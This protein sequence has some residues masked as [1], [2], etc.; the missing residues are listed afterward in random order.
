MNIEN[1]YIKTFVFII[2]LTLF[3][4]LSIVTVFLLQDIQVRPKEDPVSP[5]FSSCIDGFDVRNTDISD[6]KSF[7]Q[8][9]SG[10]FGPGNDVEVELEAKVPNQELEK[11]DIEFNKTD[12]KG[13]SFLYYSKEEDNFYLNS[14]YFGNIKRTSLMVEPLTKFEVGEYKQTNFEE[15]SPREVTQF[16][17]KSNILNSYWHTDADLCLEKEEDTA[18]EYRAS[19]KATHYYYTNES[20]EETYKFEIALDKESGKIKLSYPVS[21]DALD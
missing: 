11:V 2:A 10:Y 19:Y 5:S 6:L 13:D 14:N 17:L 21:T 15:F 7:S 20:N 4:G 3:L 1:K 16:L 9:S 18:D 12:S 8:T